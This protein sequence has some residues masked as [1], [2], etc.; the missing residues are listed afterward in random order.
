[1]S[2]RRFLGASA[3]GVTGAVVLGDAGP[4]SAAS[5]AAS[6][7]R[8]RT[9]SGLLTSL[10]PAG[11]GVTATGPR[12]SW[13]V[14]DLGPGTRQT[15]Y[16]V[17]FATTP[18]RLERGPRLWD[19]GRVAS[20]RSVA[21][22]YGGPALEPQTAYWWRVRT[23]DGHRSSRWSEPALL[24]TGVGAW[25]AEP[26]WTPAAPAPGDGVLKARVQITSVAASLWFR[27]SGTS[28]NYLWQLRAGS[29]G[30]LKKHVCVDGTYRVLE[31]KRLS[32]PVETGR[33]Y[34]VTVS[35]TGATFRTSIDGAEVDTTTDATHR[36]GT[37]GMRNGST[38][39]N[40]W[41]RVTFTAP[42]GTAIV[43]EDFTGGRGTFGAGT[44]AGGVLTLGKGQSTLSSAGS[45]DDDWALLRTEFTLERKRIIAAVLHVCAQSPAPI[46]QYPA[47][48]WV[49]G[50]VAGFASMRGGA[51]APRY[52]SFDV[53][54]AL[55]PGRRNA[56]AAL[57]FTTVDKRFLA[58]LAVT[59]ADGTTTVV[60]SGRRGG[61]A[62]RPGCSATAGRSVRASTS[63]P[64]S[65][66][67][68]GTSRPAG[69]APASTTPTGGRRRPGPPSRGSNPRWSSR[70]GCTTSSPRRSGGS[71]PGPGSSISDGRS[72]AACACRCAAGPGRPSRSGSARN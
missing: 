17:Q 4:A 35:M 59:Y 47:K 49:N 12:L 51:G 21:V 24:A 46:R 10:L 27:A 36:T 18:A 20:A 34:D 11:L 43:D 65:T 42:D 14:A 45:A 66:G 52:H 55:R 19:S 26:I 31:E 68:C 23:F 32:T 8:G 30:V 71:R 9:P 67:T 44:V 64:R 2:R 5:P 16:Q 40:A 13:Q 28:A 22:P 69:R 57:A 60:G 70:S 63:A 15:H 48:I 39:A 62:A 25:T 56:L 53:T 54:G 61:R 58:Q 33:W 29:P 1:M 72:R 41:D 7:A 37:V 3:A 50:E 38:E 6:P